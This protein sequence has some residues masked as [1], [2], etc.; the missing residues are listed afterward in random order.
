MSNL[1]YIPCELGDFNGGYIKYNN[2][3]V[4]LGKLFIFHQ[5]VNTTYY[6]NFPLN[7][8]Y[9]D[10]ISAI[11]EVVRDVEFPEYQLKTIIGNNKTSISIK[12]VERRQE[13]GFTLFVNAIFKN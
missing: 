5:P 7:K 1:K 10:I 2:F 12:D 6:F 11:T 3:I 4:V 13:H 8:T 9:A